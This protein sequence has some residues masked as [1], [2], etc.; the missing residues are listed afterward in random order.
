M[1]LWRL[2]LLEECLDNCCSSCA[3][4][5][6]LS[7]FLLKAYSIAKIIKSIII[8]CSFFILKQCTVLF[9]YAQQHLEQIIEPSKFFFHYYEFLVE[10]NR[11]SI[12][13][14]FLCNQ[15][16]ILSLLSFRVIIL[17]NFHFSVTIL[18]LLSGNSSL[19]LSASS[20]VTIPP[21][22]SGK[23]AAPLI[24]TDAPSINC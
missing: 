2:L 24:S 10:K 21:A 15:G 17:N 23:L 19:V 14:L 9:M 22:A 6:Q 3:L 12:G 20:A 16:L 8:N 1:L 11:S 4:F 5:T 13:L 7:V 18:D